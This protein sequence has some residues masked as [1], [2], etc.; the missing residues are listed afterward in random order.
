[1]GDEALPRGSDQPVGASKDQ[2]WRA[3]AVAAPTAVAS[4]TLWWTSG[5]RPRG[6]QPG[7]QGKGK[8]LSALPALCVGSLSTNTTPAVHMCTLKIPAAES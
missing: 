4:S 6:G 1:M 2:Q 7:Q 5:L 8:Q 3:G